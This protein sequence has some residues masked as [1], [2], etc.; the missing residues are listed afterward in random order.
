MWIKE[1]ADNRRK[2]EKETIDKFEA[3]S[4]MRLSKELSIHYKKLYYT[5][6]KSMFGFVCGEVYW[7]AFAAW[8]SKNQ[9]G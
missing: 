7:S 5:S 1:V 2:I 4:G 6:E 9:E 8:L 3:Q